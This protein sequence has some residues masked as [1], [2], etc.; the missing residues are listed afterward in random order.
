MRLIT[1]QLAYTSSSL[2]EVAAFVCSHRHRHHR[3]RRHHRCRR[4][5]LP[6]ATPSIDIFVSSPDLSLC[7][8]HE[9]ENEWKETVDRDP[10]VQRG[11]RRLLRVLSPTNPK[12]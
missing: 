3:H 11:S 1:R 7:P 9:D 5:R 4:R 12:T 2:S 6:N 10:A 8:Y